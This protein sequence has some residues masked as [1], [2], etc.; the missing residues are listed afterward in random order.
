MNLT[1]LQMLPCVAFYCL[2]C[3]LTSG[4]SS[5][6]QSKHGRESLLSQVAPVTV[7][8]DSLGTDFELEVPAYSVNAIVLS[9]ASGARRPDAM[10]QTLIQA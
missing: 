2:I 3:A 10:S 1:L 7:E 9:R 4:F 5:G 6:Q 8:V